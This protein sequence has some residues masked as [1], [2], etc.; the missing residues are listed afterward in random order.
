MSMF[1]Y[2]SKKVSRWADAARS[3]STNPHTQ[4]LI[5]LGFL[6]FPRGRGVCA[7]SLAEHPRAWSRGGCA[8]GLPWEPCAAA[9]RRVAKAATGC[10]ADGPLPCHPPARRPPPRLRHARHAI[11][12]DR[13]PEQG[14]A[15]VHF[16]ELQG[17]LHCLRRRRRAAQG[18]RVAGRP[19]PALAA[20]HAACSRAGVKRSAGGA[21][22]TAPCRLGAQHD[23]P[24]PLPPL[25]R[26]RE[27]S[28]DRRCCG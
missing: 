18:E 1:A 13:D 9:R 14:P 20:R 7:T 3:L 23:P 26:A 6:R 2:L 25:R 17:W 8:A 12:A 27:R 4:P 5:P 16:L 10:R 21:V 19:L 28:R 15:P 22:C 11:L 24:P